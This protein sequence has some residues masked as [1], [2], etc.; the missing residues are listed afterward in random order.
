LASIPHSWRSSSPSADW[1]YSMLWWQG[2][3]PHNMGSKQY[4]WE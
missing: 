3:H 4:K 2:P 1:G